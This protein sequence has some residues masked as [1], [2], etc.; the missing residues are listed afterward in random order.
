MSDTPRALYRTVTRS[1]TSWKASRSPVTTST[2]MSCASAWV[3][4]VAMTSS[5]SKPSAVTIGTRSASSTSRT[6]DT[7]PL[8]S[9][10]VSARPALYSL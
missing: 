1:V 8:K 6:S 3:A 9:V 5:A 4:R 7:W 2:S 10:G